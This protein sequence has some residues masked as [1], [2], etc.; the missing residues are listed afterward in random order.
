MPLYPYNKKTD[1]ITLPP[2]AEKEI[3]DLVRSGNKIEAMRRV[4]ELT[5]AG[6]KVSKDYVDRFETP[7]YKFWEK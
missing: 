6:L 1:D 5:G 7:R 4:M 2:E 3:R